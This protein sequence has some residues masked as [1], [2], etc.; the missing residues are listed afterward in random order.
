MTNTPAPSPLVLRPDFAAIA[1]WIKPGAK[2]LDLG[3]GDGSLLRYLRDTRDVFGY[4]VEI[5]E[6]NLLKCFRNGINVIQ[7]DLEAGLSSFTSYSFDYLILSRTMQ[8][9]LHTETMLRRMLRV[10]KGNIVS[11]PT[12][13]S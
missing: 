9:M 10:D 7:N 6:T 1:E 5:D 13:S 8:A 2:I 11:F 4:G 12:F 3:C